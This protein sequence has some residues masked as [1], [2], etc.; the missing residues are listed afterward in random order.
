M[1]NRRIQRTDYAI[2]IETKMD[3]KR[4]NNLLG[5]DCLFGIRCDWPAIGVDQRQIANS[6]PFNFVVGL[7]VVYAI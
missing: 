4:L 6:T 5:G 3:L 7:I 1:N 2:R